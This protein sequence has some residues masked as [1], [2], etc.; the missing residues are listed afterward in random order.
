MF[1]ELKKIPVF[2]KRDFQMLSTYKLAFSIQFISMI[3]NVFYFIFFGS[4]FGSSN[5]S[6]LS[7]YGGNFIS[8]LLIGSIGWGLLWSIMDTTGPSL[9]QEMMMGT[10]ES[11][12]LTKTKLVTMMISYALFGTFFGVLSMFILIGIGFVFFHITAFASASIFTVIIFILSATMMF[13]FALIFAGLT[14][15]LKNIGSLSLLL[16]NVTMFFCGVYFPVTV[17][18]TVFQPIA[19]YIPFYYAIEGLRRSLLPATS[20]NELLFFIAILIIL[21]VVFILLGLYF[22]HRCLTRA[23][24][25]GSLSFY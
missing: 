23:K 7:P 15:R 11:I 12:A 24:K 21:S 25:D 2:I 18:P 22:L 8:Y 10:L 16:Q 19:N 3:F 1:N 5:L 9:R 14:I 20:V 13:G 6:Q 4:M 17:L